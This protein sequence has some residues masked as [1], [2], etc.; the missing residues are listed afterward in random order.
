MLADEKKIL[1]DSGTPRLPK[2]NWDAAQLGIYLGVGALLLLWVL[3]G[4]AIMLGFFLEFILPIPVCFR[5][6]SNLILLSLIPN[7]VMRVELCARKGC[8]GNDFDDW[9]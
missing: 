4:A 8:L 2:S 9:L 3:R 5:A 7:I 1:P 6:R